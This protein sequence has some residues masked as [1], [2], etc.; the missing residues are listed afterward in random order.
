MSAGQDRTQIFMEIGGQA[1]TLL[2]IEIGPNHVALDW[3][4][5]KQGDVGNDV[6]KVIDA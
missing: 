5:P 1:P 3:P 2:S 4:G 6:F